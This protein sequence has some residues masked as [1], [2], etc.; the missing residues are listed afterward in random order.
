MMNEMK[1]IVI[2]SIYE[3]GYGFSVMVDGVVSSPHHCNEKETMGDVL[4]HVYD[5]F[6][7]ES[8]EKVKKMFPGKQ[9]I[10]CADGGIEVL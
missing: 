5:E 2:I 6:D 8:G 7:P 1:D 4:Y 9:V 10:V 3:G